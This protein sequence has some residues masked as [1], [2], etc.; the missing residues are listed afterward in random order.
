MPLRNRV[1]PWGAI[2]A[3]PARGTLMGNRGNLHDDNRNVVRPWKHKNW[4]ACRLWPPRRGDTARPLM[5]P[6]KYTE[7]FFLDEATALAA[8]HRPCGS[9]RR[10]DAN[11]FGAAWQ[12]AI[13]PSSP[14]KGV[15]DRRLHAD[16]VAPGRTKRTYTAE[17]AALPDGVMFAVDGGARLLWQ[18]RQL[19]WDWAGYTDAGPRPTGGVVEVL[20]PAAIAAVIAAGYVPAVHESAAARR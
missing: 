15:V 13:G 10:D 5:H 8:G 14:V 9:C 11:R 12:A 16:R 7:L 4:V 2:V 20:T 1:D 19:A 6:G 17:V 18:G 3:V